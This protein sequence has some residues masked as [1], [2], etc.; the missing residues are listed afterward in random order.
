M[1]LGT[2]G[3]DIWVLCIFICRQKES[4][5]SDDSDALLS[6]SLWVYRAH[7]PSY[8]ALGFL[9]LNKCEGC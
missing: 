6:A 1:G 5:V 3:C 8:C 4:S 7:A 9:V 2:F